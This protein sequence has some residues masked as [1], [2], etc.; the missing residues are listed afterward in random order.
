MLR[1]A[2]K[3]RFTKTIGLL[4]LDEAP[5]QA[6]ILRT[7]GLCATR[8]SSSSRWANTFSRL[9]ALYFLFASVTCSASL[10]GQRDDVV[11]FFIFSCRAA[12]DD[13]PRGSST[14][15][16]ITCLGFFI[17]SNGRSHLRPSGRDFPQG[18]ALSEK[19]RYLSLVCHR[20]LIASRDPP[21]GGTFAF[22]G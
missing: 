10:D 12:G 14:S 21:S 3:S 1:A 4:P 13:G 9:S 8:V 18:D 11:F 22:Q 7:H 6:R 15:M 5:V 17:S 20:V 2:L 19:R 16:S